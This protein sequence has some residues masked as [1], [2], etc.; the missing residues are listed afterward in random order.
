MVIIRPDTPG[1]HD[2]AAA[3]AVRHALILDWPVRGTSAASRRTDTAWSCRNLESRTRMR[4][5]H[6]AATSTAALPALVG[7]VLRGWGTTTRASIVLAV[8]LIGAACVLFAAFGTG[9]LV[10]LLA[11]MVAYQRLCGCRLGTR[12]TDGESNDSEP[13][14]RT[15][16]SGPSKAGE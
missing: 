4:G 14:A 8:I 2:D 5:R 6:R 9:G 1:P 11:L 16:S 7:K 15:R 10:P 3:V 12:D 13:P